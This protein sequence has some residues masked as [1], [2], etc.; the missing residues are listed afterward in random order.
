[1]RLQVYQALLNFL[2]WRNIARHHSAPRLTSRCL[3]F[4]P[5]EIEQIAGNLVAV[6][7]APAKFSNEMI[8][9]I[10]AFVHNNAAQFA[11]FLA[12]FI[13]L[14]AHHVTQLFNCFGGKADGHQLFAQKLLHFHV[15]RRAMALFD[16]ELVHGLKEFT[17]AV[18]ADQG[19]TFELFKLFRQRFGAAFTVVV[20][21]GVEF[22][23]IFLGHIVV[24]FVGVRKS[25]H[26]GGD[27]DLVFT[28]VFA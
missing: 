14:A 18:K 17:K 13:D 28:D 26:D 10:A 19:L 4:N 8:L 12:D 22:I 16:I 20:V 2:H 21:V 1:M 27:H 11:L 9:A 23:E 6:L 24:G 3:F 25:V 7:V 5:L 15:S